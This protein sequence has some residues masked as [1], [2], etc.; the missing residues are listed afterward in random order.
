MIIVWSK[1]LLKTLFN[2]KML[3]TFSTRHEIRCE[4]QQMDCRFRYKT[5]I[6]DYNKIFVAVSSRRDPQAKTITPIVTV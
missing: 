3:V 1:G 6:M 2:Q 5:H 4:I